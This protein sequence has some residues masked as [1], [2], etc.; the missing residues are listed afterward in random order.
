[1]ALLVLRRY[2]ELQSA[3][4]AAARGGA[5]LAQV[6]LTPLA[7]GIRQLGEDESA[8]RAIPA[9]ATAHRPPVSHVANPTL[10]EPDAG[11]PHVRIRGGPGRQLPGLP[12][13]MLRAT[14]K[15]RRGGP[16]TPLD[17][18]LF[19]ERCLLPRVAK[20]RDGEHGAS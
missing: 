8:A 9:P 20:R 14:Q 7:K 18:T 16:C 15:V 13:R 11:N 6:A 4:T 1:R 17:R 10:E 3:R 5:N 2:V 19:G 12:D